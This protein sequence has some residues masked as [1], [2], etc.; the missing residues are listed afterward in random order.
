MCSKCKPGYGPAVYAFS[1]V[2]AK[3]SSKSVAGWALYLFLVLV[4]I[5]VFYIFVIIFNIRATAPS[6]TAFLLMCST[7][8]MID[9]MYMPLKMKLT[10]FNSVLILW[11]TVRLFCGFRNLDFFRYIVPP[12]CV[13]SHLSNIQALSL[14]YIHVVYPLVLILVTFICIE[15]R[16]RN[17]KLVVL[18]WKPFHKCITRLRRS[19]DPRA[20][21]INAFS[22][23]LLLNFSKVVFVTS[24]SLY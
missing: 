14:E 7:Y 16:A 6:F 18:V 4:P 17:V 3:C 23:F 24:Y 8:C 10:Q 21:T 15:L 11:Q 1:L 20:S 9:L 5:T 19:W 12:F 22:T 13:S 2:C